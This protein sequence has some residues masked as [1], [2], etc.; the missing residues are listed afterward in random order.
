ME[1]NIQNNYKNKDLESL[2]FDNRD[3]SDVD[4]SGSKLKGSTF[5]NSFLKNANFKN[6]DIRGCD[7][8][9]SILA[10]SIF[11]GAKIGVDEKILANLLFDSIGIAALIGVSAGES[12]SDVGISIDTSK[13]SQSVGGFLLA[14]IFSFAGSFVFV[15]SS[16]KAWES[17]NGSS[18]F[19]GLSIFV[20]LIFVSTLCF[21]QTVKSLKEL[22]STSFKDADLSEVEF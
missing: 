8:S 6:A 16:Y 14:T 18:V 12:G 13:P 1:E 4:F 22:S 15:F 17:H 11:S 19:F 20:V 9:G 21:K 10:G 5:R 3:L 2:C 7:F